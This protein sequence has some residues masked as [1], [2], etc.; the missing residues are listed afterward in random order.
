[1]QLMA[2][3]SLNMP[4]RKRLNSHECL[5]FYIHSHVL[6]IEVDFAIISVRELYGRSRSESWT[7]LNV[8]I[9]SSK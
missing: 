3:T 6:D 5:S 2:P 4:L 9:Q 7:V 8:Y 1:M